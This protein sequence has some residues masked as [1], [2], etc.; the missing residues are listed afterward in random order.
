MKKALERALAP[1][2]QVRTQQQDAGKEPK[3]GPSPDTTMC[4]LDLELLTSR[5]VRNTFLFF[6]SHPG[7]RILLQQPKLFKTRTFLEYFQLFLQLYIFS[8][9]FRICVSVYDLSLFCIICQLELISSGNYR[10]IGISD[11]FLLTMGKV[12]SI[13]KSR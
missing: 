7:Y 4:C 6:I 1:S 11:I 2:H 12:G 3:R 10:S 8:F 5:A 9:S 13:L